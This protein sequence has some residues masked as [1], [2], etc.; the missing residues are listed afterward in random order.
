MTFK[1]LQGVISGTYAI[2][3]A[4]FT[5]YIFAIIVRRAWHHYKRQTKTAGRLLLLVV[6]GLLVAASTQ[7]AVGQTE[8]KVSGWR[9]ASYSETFNRRST[10][11]GL[12]GE[13]LQRSG[14]Q[15]TTQS[16]GL[17][18]MQKNAYL[19][20]SVSWA[21]SGTSWQKASASLHPLF[22]QGSGRYSL[23]LQ[24]LFSSP[25]GNQF[26]TDSWV[27]G[28]YVSGGN[29]SVSY[30]PFLYRRWSIPSGFVDFGAQGYANAFMVDKTGYWT[31]RLALKVGPG[32]RISRTKEPISLSLS[33]FAGPAPRRTW[34][35]DWTSSF[36]LY[37]RCG[38]T[39]RLTDTLIAE[40]DLRWNS[41]SAL[42]G[43]GTFAE[44]S[45][46]FGLSYSL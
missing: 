30:S 23:D 24:H 45:G 44:I 29:A 9:T 4:F 1:S 13:L 38:G 8:T 37:L 36:G 22:R 43:P 27:Q 19:S 7:V 35:G 46:R 34:S 42:G 6:A 11:S 10:A 28:R 21:R 41:S 40:T 15:T 31:P 12:E 18:W 16:L 25:L 39:Y 2:Y 5:I 33:G 32:V 17:I 14:S 26:H 3:T 20:A